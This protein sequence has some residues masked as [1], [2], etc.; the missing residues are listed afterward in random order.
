MSD[1]VAEGRITM[2][3]IGALAGL[4][5]WYLIDILTDLLSDN[6]TL[7]LFI[8]A[9]YGVFFVSLL[10]LIGPLRIGP[11]ALWS[12]WQALAVA[13]LLTWASL[14]FEQLDDFLQTPYALAASAIIALIPLPFIITRRVEGRWLDYSGL[15]NHSWNIVV[16]Y[17]ASWVFVGVVWGVIMLSDALFQLIGID[18]IEQLLDLDPVPFMLTG[19]ILGLGLAVVNEL[20]DYVSP[21]LV[22]RLLRL[23]LPVV[24]VVSVVFLIALPIRGLSQLFGAFSAAGTLMAMAM[25]A[26]TLVTTALDRDETHAVRSPA[27]RAMTQLTA[28]VI[29]ALGALAVAAIW[30][31]VAQYGWTPTRLLAATSAALVMGYGLS[32]ALAV[33]LRRNWG[34]RIRAAN[35]WMALV[36]VAVAVLW[37]SPVMNPERIATNS[38]IARYEAGK[39]SAEDIDLWS[40][41][42]E[43]GRAGEAG[44][45]RLAALEGSDADQLK[46][47]LTALAE[48]DNKYAF[49]DAEAQPKNEKA[50][51][52]LHELIPVLPEGLSLP[53]EALLTLNRWDVNNIVESCAKPTPA[54]NP[55]CL[56]IFL[57]LTDTHEGDEIVL[58]YIGRP[59]ELLV[60]ALYPNGA[61]GFD[62]HGHNSIKNPDALDLLFEGQFELAPVPA[63]MLRLDG[64]DLFFGR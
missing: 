62:T 18:A 45:D 26:A 20:S 16:R 52:A 1:K 57:D 8:T 4:C 51:L 44:L 32:Y 5:Q 50:A 29:P 11:A 3:T 56:A 34:A 36:L 46:Q 55:G 22:L 59:G 24:L 21:F 60:R 28:L 39:V 17:A 40:I 6:L 15:F 9:N 42:R 48:A 49:H 63:R 41:G 35:T 47:R 31:R 2:A 37:L 27:M 7:L 33:A 25:G 64:T 61:G 14:R 30:M 12:T 54:G 43:W 23:L 10:A 58:A 38:Q 19:A 53:D 13:G